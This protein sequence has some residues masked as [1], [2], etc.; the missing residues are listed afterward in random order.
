MKKLLFIMMIALGLVQT[1]P[2]MYIT[3]GHYYTHGEVVTDDGN[4]WDYSQ[5]IISDKLS[6]DNE[7][8][9]V[10]MSDA[11]TPDNIYDDEIVGLIARGHC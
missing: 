1:E 4:I 11:G 6:Y 10:I 9:Y 3:E 5:F 8:V 2:V 7:P